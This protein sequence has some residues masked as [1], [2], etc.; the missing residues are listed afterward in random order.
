MFQ[1]LGEIY[2]SEKRVKTKGIRNSETKENKEKGNKKR[3]RLKN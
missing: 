1:F 3:I 2:K